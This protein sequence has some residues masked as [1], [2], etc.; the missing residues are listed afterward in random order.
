MSPW[1]LSLRFFL[2]GVA[3]IAL[4]F[5]GW[6]LGEGASSWLLMLVLPLAAAT[7]WGVFNVPGDP[8]R[9]GKAPVPVPGWVRLII[10]LGILL[11]G[12]V[13]ATWLWGPWAAF[14][15]TLGLLVHYT[16]SG[17]RIRWLLRGG[18]GGEGAPA[19]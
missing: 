13:A 4:A 7:V 19:G 11:A 14:F 10:E 1:N 5:A 16:F 15:F 9:S 3:L 2:E 17:D 6:A 8:S 12:L 18:G